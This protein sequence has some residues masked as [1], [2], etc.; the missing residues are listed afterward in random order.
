MRFFENTYLMDKTLHKKLTEN[1]YFAQRP[2]VAF[3]DSEDALTGMAQEINLLR[4]AASQDLLQPR[5]KAID[6]IL[7]LSRAL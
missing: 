7:K 4:V 5:Q 1:K 6:N 2:W 3:A